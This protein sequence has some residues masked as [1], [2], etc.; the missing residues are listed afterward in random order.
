MLW[1]DDRERVRKNR[2]SGSD[3]GKRSVM[4]IPIANRAKIPRMP[5]STDAAELASRPGVSS[6][7]GSRVVSRDHTAVCARYV[8]AYKSMSRERP[9][10]QCGCILSNHPP[11]I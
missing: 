6:N 4:L 11:Q 5:T 9:R 7:P 1:W 3:G 8:I 10:N 2:S